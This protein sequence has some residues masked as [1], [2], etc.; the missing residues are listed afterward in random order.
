[1]PRTPRFRLQRHF[2][3]LKGLSLILLTLCVL[4]SAQ[5]RSLELS[6]TDRSWE[7]LTAVGTRAGLFGDESGRMEAWVYPLKLLRDFRLQFEAEGHLVPAEAVARTVIAR[8][9]T[10]TIM[11]AGDTFRVRET[12]F[13][14]VQEA[15][16]VVLLE[17]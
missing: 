2:S 8:P 1:M 15:G 5:E 17:I 16:A 12:L 13:V 10:S 7:F 9:E 14:P 4:G 11:Y 6:R 3:G